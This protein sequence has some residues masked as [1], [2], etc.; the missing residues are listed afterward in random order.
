[1]CP[2]L[3][4]GR[5]VVA[6]LTATFIQFNVTLNSGESFGA[7]AVHAVDFLLLEEI[8]FVNV[9]VLLR[10]VFEA[11]DALTA[12]LTLKV[13]LFRIALLFGD[14]SVLLHFTVR[15]L[16]AI[17]TGALSVDVR[18]VVAAGTVVGAEPGV[19]FQ[20]IIGCLTHG[21]SLA[22]TVLS[23]EEAVGGGAVAPPLAVVSLLGT[24]AAVEAGRLLVVAD[25]LRLCRHEDR[26]A[27]GHC[28]QHRGRRIKQYFHRRSLTCFSC[29]LGQNVEVCPDSE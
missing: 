1:M 11:V 24:F 17:G 12:L 5:S 9:F 23:S 16:V 7:N 14:G 4:T 2:Y 6:V 19:S 25:L 13:T 20:S 3:E 27:E 28:D 26:K 10:M 8:E 15:T 29:S 18:C 21:R 22:L